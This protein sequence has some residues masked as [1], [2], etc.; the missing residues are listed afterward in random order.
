MS[1]MNVIAVLITCHNRR[2]LTVNCVRQIRGQLLP[3]DHELAFF[4]MDDGSTDGTAGAVRDGFPEVN[5]LQGDGSL[6]WAGGMRAA[7]LE[8][9]KTAPDYYLCVNDDTLI[10]DDCVAVLLAM[11]GG[12]TQRVIAVAAIC[13]SKTGE[14]TYG[15]VI[16]GAS[17]NG[18]APLGSDACETFN[19]NCALITRAVFDE[20]GTFHEAF[21]HGLGDFDYGYQAHQRGI[22]IK[23]SERF[24][25]TCDANPVTGTW[26]DVRLGRLKRLGL[27][28]HEK[29]LPWRLWLL[30]LRRNFPN[31]WLRHFVS[32]YVRILLGR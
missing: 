17:P 30:Y 21:V 32:P 6:Y 18:L 10:A 23:L 20:L 1:R 7:W 31:C 9:A 11:A 2:E 25:G 22:F 27:I 5:L 26:R 15:G 14:T 4:I 28:Q 19:C 3:A 8:A 24:L 29:G 16:N 13:D 12:P